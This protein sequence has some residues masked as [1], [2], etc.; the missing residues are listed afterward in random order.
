MPGLDNK[1]SN[2]IGTKIP[3]WL[4]NQLSERSIKLAKESRTNDDLLYIANK[5]AWVRLVSSIDILSSTDVE[6]FKGVIESPGS[7]L[8]KQFVLFGGTSKY[9]NQNNQKLYQLR[10]GIGKD[11]SYGILGNDEIS[12]YGYKPMPGI[13][14]AN[15]ET[16]GR[17][18][19]V[20]A[21]TITF[22][23]WDKDQLDI[24]DTLYFK[25]GFTMFLEWGQTVYYKAGSDK[26]ES[27]EIFS[28][29]PFQ[30]NL[31]KEEIQKKIAEN[32]RKS[33]GNY[34][35][36]LG[37]VTNFDFSYNQEGGY[38][39]T[40]RLLS[41][42][43]LG[44]SIRINNSGTLP[45]LLEEEIKQ[46]NN[47]LS[48]IAK[49]A[50]EVPASTGQVAAQDNKQPADYIANDLLQ[51]LA[52]TIIKDYD[53]ENTIRSEKTGYLTYSQMLKEN[54]TLFSRLSFNNW[55]KESRIALRDFNTKVKQIKDNG[56]PT[57][58][59]APSNFGR[60][61][62]SV[63]G[64]L[65]FLVGS[66]EYYD[67]DYFTGE[68]F[69]IGKKGII[70]SPNKTYKNISLD[71]GYLKR[72]FLEFYKFFNSKGQL[73]V[74]TYDQLKKKG[75]NYDKFG[76]INGLEAFL[77]NY[78]YDV[79]S[80][81]AIF[82]VAY[83][84]PTYGLDL[85]SN[86]NFEG[87]KSSYFFSITIDRNIRS[88]IG[89]SLAIANNDQ[90]YE[91]LLSTLKDS[92][93]SNN[94]SFL[95]NQN[96]Y[97]KGGT[98]DGIFHGNRTV[99]NNLPYY[100]VVKL[101]QKLNNGYKITVSKKNQKEEIQG[102]GY[103]AELKRAQQEQQPDKVSTDQ[104]IDAFLSVTIS[105][106]DTSVFSTID[107]EN[108]LLKLANAPKNTQ[109]ISNQNQTESVNVSQQPQPESISNQIKS[110][111]NY[112]S[113]LEMM[114][115][116]IQVHA[117]NKAINKTGKKD[118]EIGRTVYQL[119]MTDTKDA[120]GGKP[121]LNQLFSTGVFS[122]IISRLVNNDIK[123]DETFF[124][125]YSSRGFSTSLLANKE[126]LSDIPRVNFKELLKAYV[127]PY[128]VNQEIIKGTSTNHPVYISLGLL[129]MILN[130]SCTIYDVKNSKDSKNQ[131]PLIYIDFNPE[132]NFCLTNGSH[133]STNPWVSLIPIEGGFEDYKK[134]FS[135][136]IL[137]KDK[138]GTI[139][140]RI[141]PVSGSK[142]TIPLFN[143][144]EEDYISYY[145]PKLKGSNNDNS[146]NIYRGR[147][148][149]I[150]VSIDHLVKLAH[151]YSYKDGTNSVYLKTFL[152]Q[153]LSDI[154]KSL[155][156]F[157]ILRL[158][159]NDQ[160]NTF[161]IVDD[162]LV[163]SLSKEDQLSPTLDNRT[164]I[165]LVGKYSIGKNI[166]IKS[167]ISSKL[168]SMIAI[169]SNSE[170]KD[171]ASL[172]INADPFGY[173]NTRY[174]DRYIPNKQ[175]IIEDIKKSNNDT[176]KRAA[177]QFNSAITDF[178]SKI[179]PAET[180]VANATNYYMEKLSGIKNEDFA[181]RAAAMI[182][183]SVNFTTD[184]VSGMAM[185]QSFTISDKLLPYTYT[186]RSIPGIPNK[187]FVNMGFIVVG[188]SHRIES[189]RWD[190]AIKASMIFLKDKSDFNGNPVRTNFV[191]GKQL[192]VNSTN[193]V[194]SYISIEKSTPVEKEAA[195][196]IA[197]TF[198]EQ[199]GYSKEQ[200]SAI[201][202]G[203]LQESQLNPN[204]I[205]PS[206]GAYG[207][208]QWL[209]DRKNRL[210]SKTDYNKLETQLAFVIEEFNGSESIAGNKLKSAKTLE[211]AIVAMAT[212]ERYAGVTINSA[213]QDVLVARETG[214]RIGY[215]KNIYN[216]YYN[217]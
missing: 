172:S 185:G 19:S 156:N 164:E 120:P 23:C 41:L 103:E 123:D 183:V 73:N 102:T 147:V 201:I 203:L 135:A 71:I 109:A 157:N 101:N 113:T 192:G 2:I 68:E 143:P 180:S 83:D 56:A 98:P 150:L 116:T 55:N 10:S 144:A 28:I 117:L 59:Y 35:A 95:N 50:N 213:Y 194:S 208:A 160:A 26:I 200:V 168:S 148:M 99:N 69:I 14:S 126:S 217:I 30:E 25:L 67:L 182:P 190:T 212:Y 151:D 124:N 206:S 33:E 115:K 118:L 161:Q 193:Q 97:Y 20:R 27:T 138:D 21:A 216:R 58:V 178:Y 134:L 51:P 52:L 65:N 130:H 133:L 89:T 91:V 77:I 84:S 198:F 29:D 176:I 9:I 106:N 63:D 96:P 75:F 159:Y 45:N 145:L 44:D 24:I 47:T 15:I 165:P 53:F 211:D 169:S 167:E 173:V 104:T 100:F 181:T 6:N 188:V 177:A 140:N 32:V 36:M 210:L 127:I 105:F 31:T 88:S 62:K 34:E 205:N 202:G 119:D 204:A 4:I 1:L 129:L 22:K 72:R 3:Q 142:E 179:N 131:T 166:E 11:G 17:L 46:L 7:D 141:G 139:L 16:Q 214:N 149:N 60:R 128:Q 42:G 8:A 186:N 87:Y 132:L 40:L 61:V 79:N 196:K 78:P 189:N 39:C 90:I 85:V 197:K 48:E 170:Y 82:T 107:S 110:E 81:K 122:D 76:N 111:L 121:F 57:F 108:D 195:I 66:K 13:I 38:D 199:R 112:Q 154:N 12:K 18:G 187:R 92:I 171:K 209:G 184:G 86:P 207:I 64:K 152:E 163:P 146:S 37:I 80:T 5:S 174:L 175:D 153:L 136:D 162:Q 191:E 93:L 43:A 74:P 137:D 158:S 70:L 155:G 94:I 114:L 125:V 49:I 54:A 215:S